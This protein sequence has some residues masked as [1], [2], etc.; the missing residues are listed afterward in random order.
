MKKALWL[1]VLA[2]LVVGVGLR[3]RQQAAA[4]KS[5]AGA[6]AGGPV[7]VAT[8]LAARKPMPV[9]LSS[10]GTAQAMV[11]VNVRAQVTGVLTNVLFREGDD[12]RQGDL[13]FVIDS[14]PFETALKQAEA[15]LA[16][17]TAQ[18]LSAEKEAQRQAELHRKGF[19]S[20]DQRDQSRAAA[21]ALAAAIK[22]DEAAIENARILLGYCSIRSPVD[23]R[24]GRL[25]VDVGNLVPAGDTTLVTITQVRP[26]K[27][28]FSVPQQ[29]L[30]RIRE[31]MAAGRLAVA[32][33]APSDRRPP[34]TG[35]LTF[36]DS[37]VDMTTGSIQ[38]RATFPNL[39]GRLWPGQFVNV[40][41]TLSV[42]RD[43]L[44]VPAPAI[45]TGQ[46]GAYV[47][48]IR[49][50]KADVRPVVVQRI[51]D[52]MAVLERGLD[53]GDVVVTDGQLRLRPG[54]SVEVRKGNGNGGAG[55]PS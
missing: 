39:D 5:T 46:K 34:E 19:S 2:A 38:L 16:R 55:A 28:L 17:D 53:V 18:H 13:L 33:S 40:V 54:A 25:N 3:I 9:T 51:Q 20:E 1:L 29:E 10:F 37:S 8:A 44:V 48:V 52:D 30:P 49:D 22:A 24:T 21:D 36:V 42:Q 14:R 11:T 41:L 6:G 12:V 35:D 32:A 45:Q 7:P 31:Q 26:I 47:F 15:S 23:G 4:R 50:G 27:V 43:A